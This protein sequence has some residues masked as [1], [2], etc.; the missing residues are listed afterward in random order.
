MAD[1]CAGAVG[2]EP[3][4]PHCCLMMPLSSYRDLARPRGITY[5]PNSLQG[6]TSQT[7]PSESS[8]TSSVEDTRRPFIL[9]SSAADAAADSAPGSGGECL[10]QVVKKVEN[11]KADWK[12]NAIK[13][14]LYI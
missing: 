3:V 2:M 7:P 14:G 13:H 1:V 6:T 5:P 9:M 8:W 4:C 11:N 10:C 12:D